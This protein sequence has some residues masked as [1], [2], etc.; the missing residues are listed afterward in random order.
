MIYVPVDQGNLDLQLYYDHVEEPRPWSRDTDGTV[1]LKAGDP[2][3]IVDL[4]QIQ[5]R[6]VQRMEGHQDTYVSGDQYVSPELSGVQVGKPI[7]ILRVTL[8]GVE[9]E[10]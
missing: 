3:A 10:G 9:A 4:T 6:A 8:N 1:T 5:G 2:V 7:R